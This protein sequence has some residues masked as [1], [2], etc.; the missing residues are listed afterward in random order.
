MRNM[1]CLTLLWCQRIFHF[2]LTS[3]G[4]GSVSAYTVQRWLK[5]YCVADYRLEKTKKDF[6]HTLPCSEI[7]GQENFSSNVR[8]LA[9]ELSVC[10]STVANEFKPLNV[11]KL[12][13]WVPRS[14]NSCHKN[15]RYE[16]CV[17][18]L[19]LFWTKLFPVMESEFST[20]TLNVLGIFSKLNQMHRNNTFANKRVTQ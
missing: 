19:S 11:I 14:L 12:Q 1:L 10:K 8:E 2:N 13:T 9:G 5:Q 6:L 17:T 3:L 7:I 15:W 16:V 18:L 20:T 4:R